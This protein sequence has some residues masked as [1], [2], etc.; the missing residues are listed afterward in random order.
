[1]VSVLLSTVTLKT[2]SVCVPLNKKYAFSIKSLL[3]CLDD[4]I[5]FMS[6]MSLADQVVDPQKDPVQ[7]GYKQI[8]LFSQAEV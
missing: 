5:N 2:V 4:K 7:T 6:S 3:L 1:M 8:G